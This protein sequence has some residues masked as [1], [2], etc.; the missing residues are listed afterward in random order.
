MDYYV[1][2][3]DRMA[4]SFTHKWIPRVDQQEKKLSIEEYYSSTATQIK[5]DDEEQTEIGYINYRKTIANRLKQKP[6]VIQLRNTDEY[7]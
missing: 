1:I 2:G 6:E 3:G 4:D 7:S 5:M